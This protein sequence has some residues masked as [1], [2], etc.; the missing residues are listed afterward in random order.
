MAANATDLI[1]WKVVTKTKVDE[2]AKRQHMI[3][4]GMPTRDVVLSNTLDAWSR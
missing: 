4:Q 2:N 1:S 3:V